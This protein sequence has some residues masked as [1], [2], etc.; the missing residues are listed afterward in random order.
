MNKSNLFVVTGPNAAGKSS[1]IR[2]R[3]SDF[4]DFA[5]RNDRLSEAAFNII[6]LNVDFPN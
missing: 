6:S 2:S 5:F 4:A 1:F 3:L